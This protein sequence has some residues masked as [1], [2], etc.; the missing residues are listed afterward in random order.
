MGHITD[1][2]VTFFL[3]CLF[4]AEEKYAFVDNQEVYRNGEPYLN[5]PFIC[6]NKSNYLKLTKQHSLFF[7]HVLNVQT[8][9]RPL[10][11]IFALKSSTPMG[12]SFSFMLMPVFQAEIYSTIEQK[13]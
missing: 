4:T 7:S 11:R 13:Q 1:T 9:H 3:Y 12:P 10:L 2:Y 8:T 6:E 5:L